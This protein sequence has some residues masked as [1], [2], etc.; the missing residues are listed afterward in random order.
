MIHVRS[1]DPVRTG[2][3]FRRVSKVASPLFVNDDSGI[4]KSGG[5]ITNSAG[6]IE[7][8]MGYHDRG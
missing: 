7:M 6:V 1:E 4:G 2:H 8:N 3:Q 5:Q